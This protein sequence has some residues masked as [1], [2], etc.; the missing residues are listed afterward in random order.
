MFNKEILKGFSPIIILAI[1]ENKAKY[2]YQ[3]A[4]EIKEKSDKTLN[5]GEGTLYP[6]LHRLEREKML[7]SFWQEANNR[8]RKY[9]S[10]TAKG[11][12]ALQAQKHE[13]QSFSQSISQVIN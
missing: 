3:I 11:R 4:Q 5:F 13:W 10:L 6:L 8:K 12:K 9:Y 7:T 2:G 1:L